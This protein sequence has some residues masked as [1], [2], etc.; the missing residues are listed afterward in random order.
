LILRRMIFCL[1]A[2]IT[3][4]SYYSYIFLLRISVYDW[5]KGENNQMTKT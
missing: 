1:L 5:D 3:K 2:A 4:Q